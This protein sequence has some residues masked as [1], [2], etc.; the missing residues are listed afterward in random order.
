MKIPTARPRRPAPVAVCPAGLH[1]GQCMGARR[2]PDGGYEITW[3]VTPGGRRREFDLVQRAS[4]AELRGVAVDLG[5][6]G[7][8]LEPGDIRGG[9]WVEV[10]TFGGGRS[11]R[12]VRTVTGDD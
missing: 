3:R 10:R 4:L 1:P 2:M 5:L 6:G 7:R 11:A 12:V 9:C 8:E